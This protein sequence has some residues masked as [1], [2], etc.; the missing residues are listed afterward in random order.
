MSEE[1]KKA[2]LPEKEKKRK[3]PK[4][5]LIILACIVGLG[6][7]VWGAFELI[8][9]HYVGMIS[10]VESEEEWSGVN[11]DDPSYDIDESNYWEDMSD[12]SDDFSEDISAII[13]DISLPDIDESE[14][15]DES[16]DHGESTTSKTPKPVSY[17]PF[18]PDPTILSGIFDDEDINYDY[19]SE[20]INI[21]LIGADTINGKSARSDTMIIMSL[22]KAKKRVS[23]ISLMRDIYVSIPG[24]KSNRINAAY[25][26]GG[27]SLLL[28]T[29]KQNFG[30]Q[31]D[32]YVAV[33]YDSFKLAVNSIGGIDITVN[34]DNYDYFVMRGM[35]SGMSKE[36]AINGTHQ[37]HLNGDKALL[38]ARTRHLKG[39]D[40][41]RTLHQR[42]LLSQFV[43]SCKG[44]SISELNDM[45]TNVLPCIKTNIPKDMLKMLCRN[46]ITYV[47]YKVDTGRLPVKY[48][49]RNI[50]GR[51]VL[52][53]P[54]K[55]MEET[56]KYLY[57]KIY[58]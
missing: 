58:N 50:S 8:L 37:L 30:L 16:G 55:Y 21:L 28:K 33:G 34:E 41:T 5:I 32:Y 44:A 48:E 31:I 26:A 43:E 4:V 42:D 46:A 22:N 53:I 17:D 40:F 15:I 1:E 25:S 47:S 39:S 35:I 45:L 38:Y 18:V 23:F 12:W 27:P 2:V 7:I 49:N 10:I 11:I 24:H 29:I 36:E 51:A 3:W 20:V 57:A 13:G 19:D 56:I 9:D 14:D 52:V 6:L 54:S